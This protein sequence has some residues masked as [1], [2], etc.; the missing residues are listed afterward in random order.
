[1]WEEVLWVSPPPGLTP[2]LPGG[3]RSGL[4]RDGEAGHLRSGPLWGL[5][6]KALGKVWFCLF[7]FVCSEPLITDIMFEVTVLEPGV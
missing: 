3:G 1:M 4:G 5:G 7:R 2:G 6:L